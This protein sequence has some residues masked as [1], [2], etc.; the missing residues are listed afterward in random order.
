MNAF[1]WC[2][3]GF[4]LGSPPFSV[5]IGNIALKKDIQQEGNHNPGATNV[6]RAGG[7]KW[8][9]LALILDVTKGALPVGMIG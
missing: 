3:F 8:Y 7:M 6:L 9:I 4:L 2:L 1:A 5:W